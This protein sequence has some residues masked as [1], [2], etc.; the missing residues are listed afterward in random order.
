M[1]KRTI[2]EMIEAE[3][4]AA[5]EHMDRK[6]VELDKFGYGGDPS[7]PAP[8]VTGLFGVPSVHYR[9]PRETYVRTSRPSSACSRVVE[10]SVE[11]RSGDDF[12]SMTSTLYEI[13]YRLDVGDARSIADDAEVVARN[14]A[15][16]WPGRAYFVEVHGHDGWIQIFQPFGVPVNR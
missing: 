15:E 5:H 11:F 4:A 10:P 12:A 1:P 14:I 7:K 6:E 9:P 16:T 2:G 3:C 8:Q 13:C